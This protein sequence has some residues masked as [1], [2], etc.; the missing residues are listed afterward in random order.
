[1]SINL[2]LFIV[3][4]YFLSKNNKMRLFIIINICCCSFSFFAQIQ[5]SDAAVQ[6]GINHQY[7]QGGPGG[8]VSFVDFD[9]DGW[10]DITLAT[11]AGSSIF[12]YKNVNGVFQK[13]PS[14]VDHTEE[15]KHLLWVD[16]D[17]DDDLDLYVTTYEGTN[18]LYR[19]N[20]NL[21]F[22]DITMAAGFPIDSLRHFGAAW[23]DYDR[24]GWLDLYKQ[25]QRKLHFS[26]RKCYDRKTPK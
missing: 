4:V 24:D 2:L 12:F 26:K 25:R 5:Y 8:G 15:S 18:R 13:I 16:F 7:L 23:A 11:A 22:T 17:N 6:V 9:G 14:V 3:V 10:D 20:G 1:M 19:N 21:E